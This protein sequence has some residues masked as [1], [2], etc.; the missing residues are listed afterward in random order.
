MSDHA[1]KP[2]T[3]RYGKVA[4]LLGGS[5]AER[6]ISLQTGAA[7]LAA[8]R[9][10][11][12]DAREIDV[13]EK[14]IIKL[15]D[16]NFDR[17]FVALHGRGGEDG[18]IQGALETLNLPYTGSRVLGSAL[19][20]DKVRCKWIWQCHGLPTPEFRQI[21]SAEDL[22]AIPE[23][24]GFPVMVKPVH[25]GS[26]CGA[27]KV[28]S[29]EGL[30]EAWR[31]AAEYD[32]RVM[33]E[34][35][36]TGGDYTVTILNGVALPAIKI[37][38]DREFYDYQAKYLDDDTRY[39][40]PCGLAEEIETEI[41]DISSRAFNSI[42]ASGWGRVDMLLDEN[43]RPYLIDVNTIPGMTGHSLTPMAARQAGIDFD[44]LVLQILD[45]SMSATNLTVGSEVVA[46]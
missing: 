26:S 27:G 6:E 25:E 45:T 29:K 13:D 32:D 23:E 35:W 1:K 4:V 10:Q 19:S 24:L 41:A 39:I 5:S 15:V 42:G 28:T 18:V 16:G 43:N 33:C 8:L 21:H 38:T 7:I 40:C 2:G 37:E 17:A 12:I 14:V 30:L 9:R 20:M 36:I 3:C 34:R 31:N 22:K 46:T 11:G 44:S